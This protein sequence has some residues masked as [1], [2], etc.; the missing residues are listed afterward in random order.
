MPNIMKEVEI[1]PPTAIQP[2][3]GW[4]LTITS[5]LG[6]LLLVFLLE[7]LGAFSWI[8]KIN[9]IASWVW[10]IAF[11]LLAIISGYV[12]ARS[13]LL[14]WVSGVPWAIASIVLLCLLGATGTLITLNPEHPVGWLAR[15][16]FQNIYASAPFGAVV[17]LM[18][19]N[20][21]TVVGRRLHAPQ[22]SF[23]CN[24]L[25]FIFIILGMLIS[26]GVREHGFLSI[27]Q[28]STV[29][30]FTDDRGTRQEFGIAL[31]LDRFEIENFPPKLSIEGVGR[32]RPYFHKVDSEWV[33]TGRVFSTSGAT[34]RVDEYLTKAMPVFKDQQSMD[35]QQDPVQTWVANPSKG[36]PVARVTLTLPDKQKAT[37]WIFSDIG[38]MPGQPLEMANGFDYHYLVSLQPGSVKVYRSYLTVTSGKQ[39][40][41]QVQVEVN[42]PLTVGKWQFTQSSWSYDNGKISTVLEVVHD[43]TLPFIYLGFLAITL[44]SILVFWKSPNSKSPVLEER[45]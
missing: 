7:A 32:Q 23:L 40:S 10:P 31:K 15:L 17:L 18:L 14:R 43:P 37:G 35:S 8:G 27:V 24:H 30:R 2:R 11:V 38:E 41:R 39:A 42:K 16:G 28:G 3:Y 29:T 12:W 26:P 1:T 22:F 33:T 34:V 6:Y 44:G 9:G 45:L 4:G 13:P 19:F 21:A 5:S 25:G 20:L 36:L